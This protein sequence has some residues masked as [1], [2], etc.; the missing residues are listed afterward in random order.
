[1]DV[2]QQSQSIYFLLHQYI[3]GGNGRF[4]ALMKT[5]DQYFPVYHR[6]KWT[7]P[8][9]SYYHYYYLSSISQGEMDVSQR[10]D[11]IY[12][13]KEPVYHRGKW[14]FPSDDFPAILRVTSISQGEMDVSQR[15]WRKRR[16]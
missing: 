1:M 6:G 9:L 3:T 8:S 2:S 15:R 11:G 13:Y 16:T 10:K 7:F 5:E 12:I 14:T 4:P